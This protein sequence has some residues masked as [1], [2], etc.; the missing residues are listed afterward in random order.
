MSV[1]TL[2]LL[3]ASYRSTASLHDC[4]FTGSSFHVVK[5]NAKTGLSLRAQCKAA[6]ARA[7]GAEV[8][9]GIASQ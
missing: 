6:P 5:Y 2:R 7:L 8:K 1:R 4:I 9:Y 3:E